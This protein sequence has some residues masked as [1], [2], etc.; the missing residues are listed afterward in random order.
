MLKKISLLL[1][2]CSIISCGYEPLYLKKNDLDKPIKS[3][4]FEGDQKTNKIIT[5]FLG[6]K[7]NKNAK[8]GYELT[9]ISKKKLEIISK[10]KSGNPSVYRTSL[11]VELI[12][13]DK[14]KIIKQKEFHTSFTYNNSQ[15]KFE[16]SQYQKN[17]ETNLISEISEKIFIFL[18]S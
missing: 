11:I 14:E 18:K 16:L 12:L 17:I 8:T 6:L 10:D 2:L 5:S 15:N 13:N 3:F 4:K 7:E 9:L 1:M